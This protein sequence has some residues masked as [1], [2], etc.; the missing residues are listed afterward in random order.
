MIQLIDITVV[1]YPERTQRFD[2]IYLFL[3]H[4]YNQRLIL[5]YSNSFENL[6][7]PK[8]QKRTLEDL[9]S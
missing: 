5:K 2:I 8:Y 7:L 1:D 3:S 6:E 9:I 4:E